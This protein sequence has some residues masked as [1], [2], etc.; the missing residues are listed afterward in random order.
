V[1]SKQLPT[2]ALLHNKPTHTRVSPGN[3][4]AQGH[5]KRYTLYDVNL[6]PLYGICCLLRGME[7]HHR[8]YTM[9]GQGGQVSGEL[10]WTE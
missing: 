6:L 8:T 5:D 1:Y 9:L 4:C 10:R 3:F 2:A 7:P